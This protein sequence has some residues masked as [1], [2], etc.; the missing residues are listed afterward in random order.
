LVDQ[1]VTLRR[2][3]STTFELVDAQIFPFCVDE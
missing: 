2:T 1:A 3:W